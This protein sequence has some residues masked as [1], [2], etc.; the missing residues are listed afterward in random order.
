MS[1]WVAEDAAPG[2]LRGLGPVLSARAQGERRVWATG[3]ELLYDRRPIEPTDF[4]GDGLVNA[5]DYT[6]WRDTFAKQ[7]SGFALVAA[8]MRRLAE[9]AASTLGDARRRVAAIDSVAASSSA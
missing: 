1:F 6:I 7:L 3:V 4:N 5:A 2:S 9:A 8:E